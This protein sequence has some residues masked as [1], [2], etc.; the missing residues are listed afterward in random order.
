MVYRYNLSIRLPIFFKKG[1]P[2]RGFG[3]YK[4]NDG[5]AIYRLVLAPC[6][7]IY[8]YIFYSCNS[9]SETC[10]KR[11]TDVCLVSR[12]PSR[13]SAHK[14]TNQTCL[15]Q[16]PLNRIRDRVINQYVKLTTNIFV[17]M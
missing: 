9:T 10:Y 16:I 3:R 14:R 15:C 7:Y 11:V 2:C 13:S 12:I 17:F 1:A 5:T 8:I 6:I 4:E